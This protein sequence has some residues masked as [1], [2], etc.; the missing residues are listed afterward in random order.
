MIEH[1]LP[2][3]VRDV[4][5]A[6]AG[7]AVEVFYG[8]QRFSRQLVTANRIQIEQVGSEAF[9]PSFT[10]RNGTSPRIGE[11]AIAVQVLIEGKSELPGAGDEDHR[12]VVNRFVDLVYGL[13]VE[14]GISRRQPMRGQSATGGFLER[15]EDELEVGARYVISFQLERSVL[16]P[17]VVLAQVTSAD[18]TALGTVAR[19]STIMTANGQT[20]VACG[21]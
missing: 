6:L 2:D 14:K 19:G 12:E 3:L 13:F 8:R 18:L 20:E 21:E 17:A 1:T 7:E 9:G 5:D 11:R 4:A 15:P 16:R 10:T